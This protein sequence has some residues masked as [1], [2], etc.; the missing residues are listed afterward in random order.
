M[1]ATAI[2]AIDGAINRALIINFGMV[3]YEKR[4]IEKKENRDLMQN[5][6][7]AMEAGTKRYSLKT[8]WQFK[9]YVSA[10]NFI[11]NRLFG[12]KRAAGKRLA[13]AM[14]CSA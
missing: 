12:R 14:R 5:S 3:Q 1:G 13:V 6:L 7:L 2:T 4:K 9:V 10:F 8:L 11:I